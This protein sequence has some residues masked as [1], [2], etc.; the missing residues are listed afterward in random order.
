MF[1][2]I[3]AAF[4]RQFPNWRIRALMIALIVLMAAIPVGELLVLKI[5]STLLVDGPTQLAGQS[6]VVLSLLAV[7]FIGFAITR[8]LHH[9]TKF[10]RVHLFRRAF[11]AQQ[12]ETGIDIVGWQ[13]AVAFGVSGLIAD[14]VQVVALVGLL[15]FLDVVIGAVCAVLTVIVLIQ[16]SALY[17]RQIRVQTELMESTVRDVEAPIRERVFSAEFSAVAISVA[18]G[19][20]LAIVV[21]RTFTG[22][23][24]L[25]TAIV[26]AMALRIF[27]SRVAGLAPVLMRFARDSL[28]LERDRGR[29]IARAAA[30]G[31]GAAPIFDDDEDDLGDDPE[32]EL[33]ARQIAEKRRAALI[34]RL[35]VEAQRGA[36]A[37]Y[38]GAAN[39]LLSEGELTDRERDAMRGADAFLSYSTPGSAADRDAGPIQMFWW[40]K[41]MPGSFDEWL[42]PYLIHASTR[43]AV[44]FVPIAG[45]ADVPP[46]LV[47]GGSLAALLKSNSIAVGTGVSKLDAR[48]NPE[49]YFVSTRGPLTARVV[50]RSGGPSIDRFGDPRLLVRRAHRIAV[51]ETNGRLVFVRNHSDAGIPFVV[52]DGMDEYP[53]AGS[54]PEQVIAA[55]NTLTGYD[56]VVTSSLGVAMICQSYGVPCSLVVLE[57]SPRAKRLDM[58]FRDHLLG[59][60]LEGDW[61][62]HQVPADLAT[63][64][65]RTRLTAEEVS[66]EKLDEIEGAVADALRR[67]AEAV[68]DELERA[69]GEEPQEDD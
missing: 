64:D 24:L 2:D 55:V 16:L 27:F 33:A 56:G 44:Q 9:M 60:G 5:F 43:R 29:L 31:G 66:S 48:V 67:H 32:A 49:A 13:W 19:V 57:G 61:H 40:P 46:H 14:L 35:L 69:L 6:G 59:A 15:F 47:L 20:A 53:I 42:N 11:A 8:G 23:L 58:E 18:T 50:D 68:S 39:R 54:R 34:D 52:P 28:R 63:V 1:R 17:K 21:W 7:F 37:E 65:W 45:G 30:G 12:A 38:H 41:P 51:G 26:L 62:L 10:W 4:G 36:S 25:A 3:F 22:A